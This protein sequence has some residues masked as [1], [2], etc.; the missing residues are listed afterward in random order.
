MTIPEY[1]PIYPTPAPMYPSCYQVND[2]RGPIFAAPVNDFLRSCNTLTEEIE[3][4]NAPSTPSRV[5]I[6]RVERRPSY[7]WTFISFGNSYHTRSADRSER[8]REGERG[9]EKSKDNSALFVIGGIIF[10]ILF[11]YSAYQTGKSISEISQTNIEIK[12]TSEF[13][14]R[15]YGF[16]GELF[17]RGADNQHVNQLQKIANLKE[18]IFVQ[19]RAHAISKL[20]FMVTLAV[21]ATLGIAG[22]L[23]ASSA[24]LLTGVG[25]SILAVGGLLVRWGIDSGDKGLLKTSRKLKEA[26]LELLNLNSPEQKIPFNKPVFFSSFPDTSSDRKWEFRAAV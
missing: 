17:A 19:I 2:E 5:Y 23:A 9:E 12:E 18:S 3:T 6:G 4:A 20:V 21:G 14:N 25:I 15:V 22:A 10:S 8:R 26:T 13:K 16:H 1:T 7:S 11:G 24:L